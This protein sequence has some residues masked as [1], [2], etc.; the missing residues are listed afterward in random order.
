MRQEIGTSLIIFT[1]VIIILLLISFAASIYRKDEKIIFAVSMFATLLTIIVSIQPLWDLTNRSTKTEAASTSETPT[2]APE[3]SAPTPAPE[4]SET[5]ET[6]TPTSQTS[7]TS[8]TPTSTPAPETSA[9][10]ISETSETPTPTSETSETPAPTPKAP[11]IKA[12]VSSDSG[13]AISNFIHVNDCVYY[14]ENQEIY[15]ARIDGS[16]NEKIFSSTDSI[17]IRYLAYDNYND[18]LII[19]SS[20]YIHYLDESTLNIIADL[21]NTRNEI[22][23]V[24][25]M[26]NDENLLIICKEQIDYFGKYWLKYLNIKTGNITS[27]AELVTIYAPFNFAVVSKSISFL[28]DKIYLSILTDTFLYQYEFNFLTNKLIYTV[29]NKKETQTYYTNGTSYQIYADG[30]S[31]SYLTATEA[32]SIIDF[33]DISNSSKIP[34]GNIEPPLYFSE[35]YILLSL[36]NKICIIEK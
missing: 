36:E 11:S 4:I 10:E 34:L 25:D 29:K 12:I 21:S 13:K 31:Y 30:I 17:Q 28:N 19:G 20:K 18:M 5:S 2:P 8:E 14:V 33:K 9:P 1:L 23:A 24:G 22:M 32:S 27:M 3:A 16:E 15:K 26:L 7:E 35:N 6:P